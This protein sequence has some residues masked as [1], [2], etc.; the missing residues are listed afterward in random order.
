MTT[1]L[2]S[3]T[4]VPDSLYVE[5][6]ADVQLHNII[7]AMQ[8]PGYVLVSRQMGKTNLLLRAKRK[9]ENSNDL[10]VY[11]DMSNIDETEKDCFE[12]LIDTAIDTHEEILGD[13][14]RKIR[15]LRTKNITKSPVQAHN[16]ELRVLLK[17]IKGKLVFILDE[18]DS[19][20]RTTFSDNVFSQ[21]RST[22]FSRVNYPDLERLTYVLSGVVEPTEIIKNP[23]ISPFN[24]GEKIHLD[25]FSHEEYLKFIN[26]ANL[27][28]LG[29]E[30]IERIFYWAGGNPRITWDICYELQH[31][32]NQTAEVVDGLVNK[33][34]LTS[35]DKAPIDT[36]RTLVK[37]DRDLR[38][39]II[40][41]AY[42]KG[43]T[44]SDKIKSKL[45]LSGIV[46]YSDNVIKIKN[47]IIKDSLSLDWLQKVEEE[48]KGLLTYAIEL[49][50]KGL[51][52]ESLNRFELFLKNNVFD[53]SNAQYYYYYMGS[54]CYHLKDFKSSLAY[55]NQKLIN[56][57]DSV[58][59][60]RN[61]QFLCGADCLNLRRYND[62]LVFFDNV[63]NKDIKDSL[64][65][66]A[67]LNSLTARQHIATNESVQ[68]S[69]IVDEYKEIIEQQEDD[70]SKDIKL[71][72]SYHLASLYL[73]K[74]EKNNA[75]YYYDEA[76]NYAEDCVK[77]RIYLDKFHVTPEEKRA[78]LLDEITRYI[79]NLTNVPTT[80]DPEKILETD[81]GVF[82]RALYVIYYYAYNR[83]LEV[84]EK[85][86]LL[87][88]SYGDILYKSFYQ[89]LL[90]NDI[91]GEGAQRLITEIYKNI[92][93]SK[94]SLSDLYILQV[95][96]FNAF[97]VYSKDAAR[98]YFNEL[99]I[100]S[101]DIDPVGLTILRMYSMNLLEENRTAEISKELDWIIERYPSTFGHQEAFSR[102]IFE[103]TL[104]VS[105][106][107]KGDNK[108]LSG[109]AKGIL[110]Y[111]DD[112]IAS[113][114]DNNKISLQQV[115]KNA[116]QALSI[117]RNREPIRNNKSYGRNDRV[118][119][120]YIQTGQVVEKKYK[121]IENDMANGKCIIVEY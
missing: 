41:L 113:A 118:R 61:E 36:I 7:D 110:S 46:N 88:E 109:I 121:Q 8:R 74:G 68:I 92:N 77:L 63:L 40:Q 69:L 80:L 42:D 30:V 111:I 101:G 45:Y 71:Y 49:H 59:E 2:K 70:V 103:Y 62:A 34:Y 95:Y 91:W 9:W 23:K 27:D 107:K 116:V 78:S 31:I 79:I 119:V 33:I 26:N 98:E 114:S 94:Y 10:Y 64:Y 20:T 44:L 43:H 108:S 56:V 1:E 22:Y 38:D 15:E 5:R 16:E 35:F 24:I 28:R 67:K 4:I 32:G 104:L 66:S 11:I 72:A 105:Y 89:S 29:N 65:Y 85:T 93:S 76:L 48:E 99:K 37:E 53:D 13:L 25:D 50:S 97:L 39:A 21:I 60:Y 102:A 86:S 47:R 51:Y 57:T 115:K 58:V 3:Y 100:S 55:M 112:E 18:I 90:D 19:L 81:D 73:S 117:S 87:Q 82:E 96:K 84:K 75:N 52:K 120:K 6:R 83:W 54:C 14:R 12:S 17:S 106:Y